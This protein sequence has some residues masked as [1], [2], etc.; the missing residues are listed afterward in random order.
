MERKCIDFTMIYEYVCF[1]SVCA[2]TQFR[3]ERVLG[4]LTSRAVSNNKLDVNGTLKR[5]F[6]ETFFDQN[7]TWEKLTENIRTILRNNDF[8]QKQYLYFI[9]TQKGTIVEIW[10]LYRILKLAITVYDANFKIFSY[11]LCYL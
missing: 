3:I 8:R 7:V 9:V 2:H 4:S 5:S 1:F 10:N 11:I 6:I